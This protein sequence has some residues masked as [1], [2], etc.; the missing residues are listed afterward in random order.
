MMQ[1]GRGKIKIMYLITGLNVGGAELV[2]LRLAKG[3]DKKRFETFV[4]S[5]LP[6]GKV[7]ERMQQEGIRVESLGVRMKYDFRALFRLI[8]KLRTERPD[9]L[10]TFLFHSNLIGRIAG[11]IAHVPIIISSI[12]NEYFGGFFR[13]RLLKWTDSLCTITTI[14]SQRAAERMRRLQIVSAEKIKVIYNGVDTDKFVKINSQEARKNLGIKGGPV[15]VSVG[16]LTEQKGYPYLFEALANLKG[17]YPDLVLLVIGEGPER[18]ALEKNVRTLKLENAIRFLGV[19]E[20]VVDYLNAA[21]IFILASL[22]EGLP[23]VVIE[24]MAC[25][26]LVIATNVGGVS[27]I[28]DDGVNGFLVPSRDAMALAQKI[29]YALE[30]SDVRRREIGAA[31][32]KKVVEHFSL[33]TM[34]SAYVELYDKLLQTEYEN[35]LSHNQI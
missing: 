15:F 17:E 5:I 22:W 7:G 3:L 26:V 32:R 14:V 1:S 21:D 27:E 13:E 11:R 20:N 30:L 25:E 16:S 18:Q 34:I 4:Y 10:H 29:R 24:A 31:A 23:N 6:I 2:L 19:R 33:E 9:I 8:A 28:I 12:R 35:F